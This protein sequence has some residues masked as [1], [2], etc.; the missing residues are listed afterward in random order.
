MKETAE[1]KETSETKA[2]GHV[3]V[4]W[5]EIRIQRQGTLR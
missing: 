1:M 3:R 2:E 5:D 4:S